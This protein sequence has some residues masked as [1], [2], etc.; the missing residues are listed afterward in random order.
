MVPGLLQVVNEC[1]LR[2][3]EGSG[4]GVPCHPDD[5]C[6]HK[7]APAWWADKPLHWTSTSLNLRHH[8]LRPGGLVLTSCVLLYAK[9]SL[10]R[11]F[12]QCPG[13]PHLPPDLMSIITWAVLL[14]GHTFPEQAHINGYSSQYLSW[15]FCPVS[16][17]NEM[18]VH[19]TLPDERWLIFWT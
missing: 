9:A 16:R 2:S 6:H 15:G 3:L 5:T 11:V 4:W 1:W 19:W 10:G 7:A 18:W 12:F 8:N 14:S 13:R 17:R